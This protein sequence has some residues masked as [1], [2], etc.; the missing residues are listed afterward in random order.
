MLLNALKVNNRPKSWAFFFNKVSS[1]KS[2]L[3]TRYLLTL[4]TNCDRTTQSC[5]HAVVNAFLN[6]NIRNCKNIDSFEFAISAARVTSMKYYQSIP[7]MIDHECDAKIDVDEE[8][9]LPE[10]QKKR[11]LPRCPFTQLYSVSV[12]KETRSMHRFLRNIMKYSW[13]S[14]PCWFQMLKSVQ[15]CFLCAL[16]CRPLCSELYFQVFYL[17]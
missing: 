11:V 4:T 16:F 9:N 10:V 2:K 17:Q 7:N 3:Q 5:C 13:S 6:I 14:S 8:F 15:V 12:S 1:F